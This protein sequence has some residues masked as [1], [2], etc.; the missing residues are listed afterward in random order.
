MATVR[1]E[2][3]R[4]EDEEVRRGAGDAGWRGRAPATAERSG[5]LRRPSSGSERGAVVGVV[6]P[7]Q[8]GSGGGRERDVGASGEWDGVRV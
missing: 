3:L 8:I 4:E 7:I 1:G 6:A 2:R 5:E